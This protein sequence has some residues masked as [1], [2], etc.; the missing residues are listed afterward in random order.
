MYTF[1]C[2]LSYSQE[3]KDKIDILFRMSN[4]YQNKLISYARGIVII[5]S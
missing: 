1:E 4:V 5:I 2:N 3:F